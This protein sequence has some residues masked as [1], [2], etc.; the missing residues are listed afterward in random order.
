M[1]IPVGPHSPAWLT[2]YEQHREGIAATLRPLN[3]SIDQLGSTALASIAAKPVIDILVGVDDASQFDETVT[4]LLGAGHAYVRQF[5]Q[6]MP[7]RRFFAKLRLPNG[8]APG[9]CRSC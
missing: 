2:V 3:P 5:T 9:K 8:Q 4:P 6:G 1:K 7:Y